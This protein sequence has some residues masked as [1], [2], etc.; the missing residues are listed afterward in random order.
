MPVRSAH[1][2]E[3]PVDTAAVLAA[4]DDPSCGATVLMTG[5]VRDHHRGRSVKRLEY[6][7][8]RAMAEKELAAIASETVAR[9]PRVH[10]AAVHRLGAMV[11]GEVSV[12][13]AAAAPHRSEAFEACRH[14]ID[15]LKA[16]LPLWKK[17]YG[18]GGEVWQEEVPLAPGPAEA[19]APAKERTTGEE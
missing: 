12:A 4:V 19:P 15:E 2:T 13:V 10:L 9:W 14:C 8:Y 18:P 11:V 17:E 5:Q 1:L 3:T 7:A 6:H 16:R